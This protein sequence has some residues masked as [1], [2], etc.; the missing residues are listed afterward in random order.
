[1]PGEIKQFSSP[2]IEKSAAERARELEI[3]TAR[4][5]V[6][7]ARTRIH[8]NP[9]RFLTE[10]CAGRIDPAGV[11]QAGLARGGSGDRR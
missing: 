4:A 3:K 5:A 10:A 2:S 6:I 11:G 8:R 1:V 9:R 7:E